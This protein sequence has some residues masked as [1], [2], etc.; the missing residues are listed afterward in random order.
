MQESRSAHKT[1]IIR[2]TGFCF[3]QFAL[4]NLEITSFT[5]VGCRDPAGSHPIRRTGMNWALH[6]TRCQPRVKE[7]RSP[8]PQFGAR[9]RSLAKVSLI[10]LRALG[11]PWRRDGNQPNPLGILWTCPACREFDGALVAE[12][13]TRHQR[14][15]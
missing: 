7:T 4:T 13:S 1:M 12:V 15:E 8:R 9:L 3:H 5:Q 6:S 10:P 11:G 14:W 2:S